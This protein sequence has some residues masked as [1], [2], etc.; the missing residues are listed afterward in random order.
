MNYKSLS[1]LEYNKIT[2]KL[3]SYAG[4]EA[5]KQAALGLKPMTDIDEIN[6]ALTQTSDALSRIYAKGSVSFSG[7]SNISDS[8]KRLEVGSTLSILELLRISALLSTAAAAKSHYEE[9]TDSLTE[10]FNSLCPL[11]PLNT[12]I[13]RCIISEEEISDDASAALRDLRRQ[14]RIAS[15]RIHTE[16]NKLLNS[17]STRSCLQ[18]YV[19]TMRQGRYC[20]PVK[21]EYKSQVAGMIHDQ[22]AT[23]STL[24][25]EPAAVVKLNNDIRELELK[26]QAEIERILAELSAEAAGFTD[27]L[28]SNYTVLVTLDFIFAKAQLSK[29]YNCSCPVMNTNKYINIKK[30]RH[31]LIPAKSVVPID[32]YLG[33]E[34]NLLIVTGPNT[35]GKT[36][37]LKTVGLLTLMA[38]SGLHIPAVEHSEI[39]VFDNIFADIGD[40]QSIEQSLSTF[41]S[42]MTN[43]ASILKEADENSLILF[44][45]I[46][47]GTDPDE[48]AALAIAI[49]SDLHN[50]GITDLY[51][52]FWQ[53]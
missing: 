17:P 34:F 35:G 31:P 24:F 16:L 9:T 20:L 46:G 22:S 33:R 37:S 15:D 39:A 44:D 2:E 1:T 28:T 42:H 50:R 30:G 36:V 10:Y 38:Q 29:H 12:Q 4:C 25:I 26:E 19:I 48:G 23:G 43:T 41:S 27:E 11:T 45:E 53:S 21:A 6:L 52:E 18:D 13:K 51:E 7:V 8:V 47:A 5:A 32:I 3:A 40:E 14:K 49:L